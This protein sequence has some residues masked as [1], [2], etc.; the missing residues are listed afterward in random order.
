[1]TDTEKLAFMREPESYTDIVMTEEENKLKEMMEI[2]PSIFLNKCIE[3]LRNEEEGSEF[4]KYVQL[5]MLKEIGRPLDEIEKISFDILSAKFG[6]IDVK[7]L[8]SEYDRYKKITDSDDVWK[9][10]KEVLK[11]V[12]TSARV[13]HEKNPNDGYS[14]FLGFLNELWKNI[15]GPKNFKYNADSFKE[16]SDYYFKF[17]T[18]R[19]ALNENIDIILKPGILLHI[20]VGHVKKYHIPRKGAGVMFSNIEN[21]RELLDLLNKVI[22]SLSDE[23][24]EH[25]TKYEQDQEYNNSCIEFNGYFYGIHIDKKRGI[26]TFYEKSTKC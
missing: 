6:N 16:L 4:C 24:L 15:N 10:L 20:L 8:L 25:F 12:R 18:E 11:D 9:E 26:K 17:K 5:K 13:A 19:F 7:L 23:L 1:M 3:K 21:P 14:G 22:Y 2:S